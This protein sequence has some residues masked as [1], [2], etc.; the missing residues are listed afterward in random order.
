MFGYPG[1]VDNYFAATLLFLFLP[2]CLSSRRLRM[3]AKHK[4]LLRNLVGISIAWPEHDSKRPR[5]LNTSAMF[6]DL[7]REKAAAV[8]VSGEEFER[9]FKQ[10]DGAELQF[11]SPGTTFL[12]VFIQ[13]YIHQLRILS[14]YTFSLPIRSELYERQAYLEARENKVFPKEQSRVKELEAEAVELR[15]QQSILEKELAVV[16]SPFLFA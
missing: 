9:S 13:G 8:G 6:V 5:L 12:A 11:L 16:C 7:F 14:D 4:K 3:L 2:K 15:K 1:Q 10:V